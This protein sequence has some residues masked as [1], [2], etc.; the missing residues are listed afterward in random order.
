[1]LN[2]NLTTIK[3]DAVI[4]KDADKDKIYKIINN[5]L[6]MDNNKKTINI[7]EE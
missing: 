7:T 5:F 4:C 2:P 3:I 6:P 1:M